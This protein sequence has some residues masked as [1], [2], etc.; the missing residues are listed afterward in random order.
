VSTEANTFT[1]AP[2]PL[3]ATTQMPSQPITHE[4]IELSKGLPGMTQL[5]V[6]AP[7]F[8]MPIQSPNQLW[9]GH[10]T[11]LGTD[12]PPQRLLLPFHRFTRRLQVPVASGPSELVLRQPEIIAQEIQ[13]LAGGGRRSTPRGFSRLISNPSHPSN[14]PSI[15]P[16][17]GGL[18]QRA[19]TT[20]SSA[21]R[22]NFACAHCAGPSCRLNR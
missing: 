14:F 19:T 11:P 8:E 3:A 6:V 22:T 18:R 5:E 20:K 1:S 13:T 12:L 21:Q 10:M 2:T 17:S 15:H 16:R 4:V 9:H 7:S